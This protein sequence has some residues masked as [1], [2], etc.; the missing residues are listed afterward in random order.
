MFLLPED[1][2]TLLA[3]GIVELYA[4]ALICPGLKANIDTCIFCGFSQ[5]AHAYRAMH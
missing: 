5:Y 3:G 2:Q 1:M 4:A